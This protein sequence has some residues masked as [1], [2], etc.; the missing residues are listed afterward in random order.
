MVALGD[1]NGDNIEDLAVGKIFDD[2]G[3][4]NRGSVYILFLEAAGTLASYQKISSA[5]SGSWTTASTD[6][7]DS[8]F[9]G[10]SLAFGDINGDGSN[11]ELAVGA[12]RFADDLVS[13]PNGIG[14]VWILSL[15]TAGLVQ[16][17]G[18][19]IDTSSLGLEVGDQFGSSIA[20]IKDFDGSGKKV[21]AVGAARDDDSFIDGGAVYLLFLAENAVTVATFQKISAA[22]GNFDG[23]FVAKLLFGRS[24]APVGDVNGDGVQDLIVGAPGEGIAHGAV[25]ILMLDSSGTVASQHKISDI[26]SGWDDRFGFSLAYMAGGNVAVGSR[27]DDD[28][29][30]NKGAVWVLSIAVSTPGV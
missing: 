7:N 15:D 27:W 4:T 13:N 19:K 12:T 17:A 8:D 3:G 2:D 30:D 21:L 26:D 25:Y 9:F 14:A 1:L 28:N 22:S 20:L 29:G 10:S 5:S 18:Q 16:A 11:M 6:L 24:I 23:E